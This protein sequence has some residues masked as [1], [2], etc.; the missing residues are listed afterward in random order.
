M[1]PGH[2]RNGLEAAQAQSGVW[3][4][5]A[6]LGPT[7]LTLALRLCGAGKSV[8]HR[9]LVEFE[10][11]QRSE[12]MVWG[13]CGTVML[14]V[15]F[16]ALTVPAHGFL[17]SL[18]SLFGLE[19]SHENEI[20]LLNAAYAGSEEDIL[21]VHKLLDL[22]TDVNYRN[23]VRHWYWCMHPCCFCQACDLVHRRMDGLLPCLRVPMATAG[24]LVCSSKGVPTLIFR[25]R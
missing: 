21:Q 22:D 14:A 2:L 8:E 23:A 15:L 7:C 13:R 24:W 11:M 17:D 18:K 16:L 10:A 1:G 6:N 25:K 3:C 12:R 5:E 19:R 4:V 20:A 9:C